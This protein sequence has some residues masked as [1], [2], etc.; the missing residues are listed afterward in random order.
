MVARQ[1]EA[2][3]DGLIAAQGNDGDSHGIYTF[4][5]QVELTEDCT[6]WRG[7]FP[8]GRGQGAIMA[9]DRVPG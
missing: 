9:L 7:S 4:S 2:V 5:R 1:T 3:K 6:I 8:G